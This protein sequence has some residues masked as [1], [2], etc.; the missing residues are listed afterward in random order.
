MK[1]PAWRLA[2]TG[3]ALVILAGAGIGLA[4]AAGGDVSP[5]AEAPASA[6][7]GARERAAGA[8]VDAAGPRDVLRLLRHV[9]HGELTVETRDGL[10]TIQLDRGTI[11]AIGA[12]SLTISEAGGSTV[13]VKTDDE[14]RVWIGRER[15]TLDDLN[16][17]DEVYV[18]SRVESNALAKRIL[19]RPGD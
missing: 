8:R 4:S 6:P 18:Q 16:I 13:V 12:S 2:L 11:K 1:I 10:V 19:V 17:G 3:G 14:T 15:G 5:A 9:V 7:D